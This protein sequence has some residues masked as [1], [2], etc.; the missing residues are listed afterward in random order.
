MRQDTCNLLSQYE[1]IASN[2]DFN[3]IEESLSMDGGLA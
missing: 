3:K 2:S 1:Y